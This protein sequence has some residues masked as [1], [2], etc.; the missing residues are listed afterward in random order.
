MNAPESEISTSAAPLP[1][2]LV[3]D[4]RNVL[5]S[6]RRLLI[7]EE[8]MEILVADSG[9][10]GLR[11]LDERPEVGVIVSDQRMPEMSGV[12]FLS[13]ARQQVPDTL[14]I[15]LTGYADLEATVDAINRGGA[16]R[17]IAKP[18]DDHELVTTLREAVA[19]VSLQ[20]ENL[21][22]QALVNRKNEELRQWNTRL[23]S[24]VLEQTAEIRKKNEEL[25]KT[26]RRL[27]SNYR[28]TIA[29]LSG[30]LEIRSAHL[31]NHARRV[32]SLCMRTAEIMELPEPEREDLQVAALLHDV[33]A[34][35]T[36]DP[37]IRRQLEELGGEDLHNYLQHAIRGQTAI[38][39]IEDL[40]TAGILIRHH[41]EHYDGGGYPDGLRG[42][43]IPLGSRIIAMADFIERH[44]SRFS[45]QGIDFVLEL[46]QEQL[47][48]RFDTSIYPF[49][50]QSARDEYAPVVN[51]DGLK[52]RSLLPSRLRMGMILDEDLASNTGLLLLARGTVIDETAIAAIHRLNEI[53]PL[54]R[55][56]SVLASE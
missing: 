2:L 24:R 29:V 34:I 54:R 51:S 26:N 32:A 1:I 3:D 50:E 22:L 14:R 42:A 56:I 11:I 5:A 48:T 55:E 49:V 17:Y 53:D 23:K 35:G 4:E 40:R 46:L 30:L 47:G 8:S 41:H 19:H 38:D 31:R 25:R 44:Q 37:L 18:W 21:R 20:R 27:K 7:E 9:K 6:L 39:T 43:D 16:Y 10:E 13:K 45:R 36:P 28:D 12:E 33:G 52:P 15:L